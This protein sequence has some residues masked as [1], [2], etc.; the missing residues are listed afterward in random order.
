MKIEQGGRASTS[1]HNSALGRAHLVWLV[2]TFSSA[3]A[4]PSCRTSARRLGLRHSLHLNFL[5]GPSC[6][7]GCCNAQRLNPHL[8]A[9]PPGASASTSCQSLTRDS[10]W[11]RL[12]PLPP[13]YLSCATSPSPEREA[14]EHCRFRCHHGA[15][16]SPVRGLLCCCHRRGHPCAHQ[17]P[18]GGLSRCCPSRAPV[19]RV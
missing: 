18:A 9:T 15:P 14:P 13:P 16:L 2:V 8:V 7:V 19:T 6:L 1:R 17:S 3:S 12:P 11:C 10:I 5:S 4:S